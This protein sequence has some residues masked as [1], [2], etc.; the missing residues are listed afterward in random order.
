MSFKKFINELDALD[1]ANRKLEANDG[2]KKKVKSKKEK[3]SSDYDF[4]RTE[5]LEKDEL[6][7][8]DSWNKYIIKAANSIEATDALNKMNI[9]YQ[10]G[11]KSLP[12]LEIWYKAYDESLINKVEKILSKYKG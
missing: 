5:A 11:K 10:I 9:Q 12:Y 3:T 7:E 6:T 1:Y 8:D 2:K 4:K